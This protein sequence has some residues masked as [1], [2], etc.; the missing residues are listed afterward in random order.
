M[1]K[2]KNTVSGMRP[3]N[4]SNPRQSLGRFLMTLMVM[5]S[6]IPMHALEWEDPVTHL[7]Y[8]YYGSWSTTASVE[9][10][11]DFT[12]TVLEI[13][14]TVT[15]EG[16]EMDVTDISVGAFEGNSLITTLKLNDNLSYIGS[17]A[18]SGCTSLAV[19]ECTPGC[20]LNY[21][22]VDAFENTPF[23]NAQTGVFVI[24]NTA[25]GWIGG[26]PADGVIAFAEGIKAIGNEAFAGK[27]ELKEVRFPESLK[28]IGSGSFYGCT[29]L[30][31]V[32]IPKNVI[33]MDGSSFAATSVSAFE[34]DPANTEL[35]VAEDGSGAI[36]TTDGT[37]FVAYP[38]MNIQTVYT[39]PQGVTSIYSCAFMDN[40]KLQR[41]VLPEGVENVYGDAIKGTA[42]QYLDIP[43]TINFIVSGAIANNENLVTLIYR[44]TMPIGSY[45]SPFSTYSFDPA[46]SGTWK[47][48]TLYVPEGSMANFTPKKEWSENFSGGV[49]EAA[50]FNMPAV[51]ATVSSRQALDLSTVGE[52]FEVYA[53]TAYADNK[54]G[55]TR[56]TGIVPGNTGLLVKNVKGVAGSN[57]AILPSAETGMAPA[58]NL[59]VAVTDAKAVDASTGNFYVLKDNMFHKMGTGTMPAFKA[60][61]DLT[62]KVSGKSVDITFEN[63]TGINH[64]VSE[65]NAEDVWHTLNGVRIK[66]PATKGIYIKNGKKVVF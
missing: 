63:V 19:V 52:D 3:C 62:G 49:K 29:G 48:G 59:L 7:V 61:L 14:N 18:F 64:A 45:G 50:L 15:V 60:Y 38:P 42:L 47:N 34:V 53:A 16:N 20:Q 2:T 44:N 41:L 57:C 22:P 33:D 46:G 6:A 23:L 13:P 8:S 28:R 39:V 4:P 17:Y 35:K 12:G 40:D 65:E 1:K 51:W 55:V 37:F 26:I 36:I 66:R 21:A 5:L 58:A 54:V 56:L 24:N 32:V 43:S 9:K 27:T 30:T 31:G 25:L 11:P 10:S